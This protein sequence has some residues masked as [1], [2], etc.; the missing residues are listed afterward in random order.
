MKQIDTGIEQTVNDA[1]VIATYYYNIAG[2][3]VNKPEKG[4][5]I[6]KQMLKDGKSRSY[7][8]CY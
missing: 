7:K 2:E 6:V 3:K 5:Y 4:I 8:V 1:E